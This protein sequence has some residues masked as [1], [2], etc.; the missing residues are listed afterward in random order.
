MNAIS[1]IVTAWNCEPLI[2]RTLRTL[3]EAIVLFRRQDSRYAKPEVVVVDDGSTDGTA[4]TVS[5]FIHR[6]ANWR[7]IRRAHPSSP[8]CARNVGVRH[9]QGDVLFFLDGDDQF[10]PGHLLE[11]TRALEHADVDFVKTGVRLAD[12]VHPDWK[13][14]IE[15]S[16]VL[17][18]CIRRHCHEYFGGFPDYHLYRRQGDDFVPEEDIFYKAEDMF[19]N[20]LVHRFFRGVVLSQETVEYCRHPGN[21]YDRQY[22]KFRRPFA[23]HQPPTGKE[24]FRLQLAEVLFQHRVEELQ[25]GNGISVNI[26]NS[27]N[28]F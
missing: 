12:P 10:L 17:N 5:A 4:E 14:R 19:Y 16:I 20:L 28:I 1:V 26:R 13:P 7:L 2:G 27:E 6:Q 22:E 24:R 21:S 9:A 18:L 23:V 15:F 3:A 25:A 11:C 8:S